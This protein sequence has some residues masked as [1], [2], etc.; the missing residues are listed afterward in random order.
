MDSATRIKTLKERWALFYVCF[1]GV[2]LL[3]SAEFGRGLFSPRAFG[4][5]LMLF[6]LAAFAGAVLITK[7]SAKEFTVLLTGPSIDPRHPNALIAWNSAGEN[8]DR[9]NGRSS[10]AGINPD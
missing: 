8:Q 5:A 3:L 4:I 1:V 10:G 2:G 6:C 9:H 7:K